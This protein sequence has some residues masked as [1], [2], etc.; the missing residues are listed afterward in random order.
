[1]QQLLAQVPLVFLLLLLAISLAGLAKSSDYLVDHASLLARKANMSE[2]LIGATIISIGTTLPEVATSALASIDGSPEIALGNLFGSIVS[3]LTFVL[4]IGALFGAIPVNKDALRN[5]HELFGFLIGFIILAFISLTPIW[6]FQTGQIPSVLG[7][8]FL[9]AL[10]VHF[11]MMYRRMEHDH[12]LEE[13]CTNEEKQKSTVFLLAIV[14]ISALVLT[15]FANLLVDTVQVIALQFGIPETLISATVVSL[16]TSLPELSTFI[17]AVKKDRTSLALGNIIGAC[18]LNL[19]LVLP[20]A[21]LLSPVLIIPS[22]YFYFIF[23]MILVIA[24]FFYFFVQNSK[25]RLITK[26]EGLGLLFLYLVYVLI[27]VYLEIG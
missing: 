19:L 9:I 8:L 21:P 26:K 17:S 16:G 5:F 13:E 3:N 10:C 24:L 12:T 18:V 22:I 4:G 6:P 7:F 20:I 11:V 14:I 25:V 27:L 23:P 2:L 15:F 1:M